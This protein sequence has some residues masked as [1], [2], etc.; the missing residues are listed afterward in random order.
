MM[1]QGKTATHC[2]KKCCARGEGGRGRLGMR[3]G[4]GGGRCRSR[5][6]V[7]T[8]CANEE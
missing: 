4:G 2:L 5:S 3:E 8:R 6:E 1:Y 7:K